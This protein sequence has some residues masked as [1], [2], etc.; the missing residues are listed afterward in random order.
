[1]HRDPDPVLC[2]QADTCVKEV[3]A[4]DKKLNKKDYNT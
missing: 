3:V 4:G 2:V 1:M